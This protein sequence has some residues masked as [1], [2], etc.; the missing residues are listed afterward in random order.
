MIK[1]KDQCTCGLTH[2]CQDCKHAA[3]CSQCSSCFIKANITTTSRLYEHEKQNAL[4]L[5]RTLERDYEKAKMELSDLKQ[6]RPSAPVPVQNNNNNHNEDGALYK[7]RITTLEKELKIVKEELDTERQRALETPSFQPKYVEGLQQTI[8]QQQKRIVMLENELGYKGD[9]SH[10]AH[11]IAEAHALKQDFDAER[12]SAMETVEKLRN[13]KGLLERQISV[14][15]GT[16]HEERQEFH[17][18]NAEMEL[19]GK[20]MKQLQEQF[21]AEQQ[22]SQRMRAEHDSELRM[23]EADLVVEKK[24]KQA[25]SERLQSHKDTSNKTSE[26]LERELEALRTDI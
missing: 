7:N 5:I 10:P 14:L 6:Q 18:K 4:D 25:L 15:K 2:T 9:P 12:S 23:I 24:A 17:K 19:M 1:S 16:L 13:D 26:N 8:E 22:R 21:D 3:L 20:Q 11:A